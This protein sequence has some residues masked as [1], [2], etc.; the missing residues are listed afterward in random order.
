MHTQYV[1]F[2]YV[3]VKTFVK[4]KST[5]QILKQSR[6][7]GRHLP[8]VI[9][10]NYSDSR[11]KKILFVNVKI[12]LCSIILKVVHLIAILSKFVYAR[13]AMTSSCII[14]PPRRYSKRAKII[15]N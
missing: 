9:Y 6:C 14:K 1:N 15:N 13:I 11:Y 4:Y 5:L 3:N 7:L 2:H 12:I 8:K 10:N